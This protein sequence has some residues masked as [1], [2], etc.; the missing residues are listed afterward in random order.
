MKFSTAC[1]ILKNLAGKCG[2]IKVLV[3]VVVV[4]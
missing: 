4:V 3:F 2:E 1:R